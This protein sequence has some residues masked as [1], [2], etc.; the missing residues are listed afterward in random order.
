MPQMAP[1]PPL[2]YQN[3]PVNIQ[4]RISAEGNRYSMDIIAEGQFLRVPIDMSSHDLASLTKDLQEQLRKMARDT[5]K[6]G[7]ANFSNLLAAFTNK[8][9]FRAS[10]NRE[11]SLPDAKVEKQ[12]RLMAKTG[13]YAF[14]RI[15][16]DA[17]EAIKQLVQRSNRVNFQITSEDFF[18]PWECLY[19]HDLNEPLAPENF[20]G[21]KH[22]IHRLIAQTRRS[23]AFVQPWINFDVK[24]IVRLFTY[25]GLH[26]V[27]MKEIPYFEQLAAENK[28]KLFKLRP[29][30][31]I[32]EEEELE[33]FKLFLSKETQIAHFACHAY[34]E[35]DSPHRSSFKLSNNFE[36]YLR[37]LEVYGLDITG[38]PLLIL[39][40]CETGSINPLYTSHFAGLFLKYG[41]RGVVATECAVPD[42]FAADF[43]EQL[44]TH[45][46]AGRP[47][48]E[49]LLQVRQHF[50]QQDGN[51]SGL[52]YAMYAPPS[53]RLV[54][55]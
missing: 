28:I 5:S 7:S 11:E 49:S 46:L 3:Y 14:K 38:S 27:K 54:Y 23:G 6:R 55:E 52:L 13:N 4:L 8:F 19:S 2:A 21:M 17:S 43:T 48:G 53:I 33:E 35:K 34:H 12:L 10:S 51:P 15:F 29:L 1:I 26:G 9:G 45:L 36:I 20:W 25:L 40:A 31:S 42:S 47:L 22:I 44:Y 50:W 39:N 32:K 16:G 18:F 37:D 30:F 41:A 24:P